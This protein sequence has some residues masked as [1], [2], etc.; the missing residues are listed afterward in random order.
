MNAGQGVS[1][2]VVALVGAVFFGSVIG[3][4]FLLAWAA[5]QN[6]P[7]EKREEAWRIFIQEW[8]GTPRTWGL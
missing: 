3:G 5:I 1:W 6:L 4:S 2:V 8:V 7:P